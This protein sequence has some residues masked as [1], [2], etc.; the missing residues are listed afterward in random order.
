[1]STRADVRTDIVEFEQL[2]ASFN[3]MAAKSQAASQ[4][5]DD[6]LGLV[7]HELKTPIT[8][9]MGNA[10]VLRARGDLLDE[11]QRLAALG[12]IEQG[13]QRLTAIIDNMLALARLERGTE[14]EHEPL[15]LLRMAQ[16]TAQAQGAREGREVLV[17]GEPAVMALGSEIY[18]EQVLQNL[19]ANAIK[20]SPRRS[21]V[22]IVVQREDDI[23]VVRVLDTG[24]GVDDE[25]REA[26]FTPFYRSARSSALA[27]GVGIGLSVCKRLVD[28]MGGRIWTEDVP[29]GGCEFG[30]SLPVALE[31]DDV[32]PAAEPAHDD[33][34][35]V[36]AL[37]L[38]LAPF[39]HGLAAFHERLHAFLE[40]AG[41]E[42][43]QQLQVDVVDVRLE[44]SPRGRGASSASS[45]ARRAA[46]CARSRQ[47]VRALRPSAA[48][49]ARR[50]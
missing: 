47:P 1:M 37:D 23:A 26:I 12:D 39:E 18:V 10:A 28:A 42:E 38:R 14:L 11:E 2:G 48:H 41:A 50:G 8:I 20:Y 19:V 43:R 21:R 32:E 24:Q 5:K 16:Q 13:A 34:P 40:V 25:D 49:Q 31:L 9:V 30:F 46:R 3:E 4:A 15:S 27:E 22:E 7:S 35:L 29:G 44:G 33:G 36:A 6:F 17:R 45:P